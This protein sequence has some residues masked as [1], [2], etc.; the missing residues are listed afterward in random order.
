MLRL[1]SIILLIGAVCSFSQI[2]KKAV[3][4]TLQNRFNNLESISFKF[5]NED[6]DELKGQLIAVKGNKYKLEIGD[7]IIVSDSDTVWNYSIKENTVLVSEFK[8]LKSVSIENIFFEYLNNSD[9]I[10]LSKVNTSFGDNYYKLELENT[11]EELKFS[12]FLNRNLDVKGFHFEDRDETWIIENLR[13]NPPPPT[14]FK[15]DASEDAEV[16]QLY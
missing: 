13:I 15:F 6:I 16:I 10:S 2:S 9:P 7:K 14:R 5:Y 8:D 12:L 3:L 1:S 11:K 4:D